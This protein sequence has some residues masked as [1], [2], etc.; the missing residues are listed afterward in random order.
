MVFIGFVIPILLFIIFVASPKLSQKP[1]VQVVESI[2]V[3]KY[4]IPRFVCL[5]IILVGFMGSLFC[6]CKLKCMQYLVAYRVDSQGSLSEEKR[7]ILN[8]LQR[9]LSSKESEG[10][11]ILNH[12]QDNNNMGGPPRYSP[13]EIENKKANDPEEQSMLLRNP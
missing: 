11:F 4:F 9:Q 2:K 5:S 6:C 3:D 10:N 12:Q 7:K 1:Q 8:E 13:F